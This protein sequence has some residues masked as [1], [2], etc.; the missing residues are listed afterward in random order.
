[1]AIVVNRGA[2]HV[3]IPNSVRAGKDKVSAN[4]TKTLIGVILTFMNERDSIFALK[5]DPK[6]TNKIKQLN[7]IVDKGKEN[8]LNGARGNTYEHVFVW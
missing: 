1:M 4:L 8:A 6:T 3:T 5:A 2:V 7:G